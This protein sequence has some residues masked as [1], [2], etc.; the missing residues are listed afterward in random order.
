MQRRIPGLALPEVSPAH[1]GSGCLANHN[2]W[3]V[4]MDSGAAVA[5]DKDVSTVP[6]GPPVLNRILITNDDGI[7]APGL[8]VMEAIASELAREIW[9]VAPEHDQ[10]GISHAVSLHNPLRITHRPP[11]AA[12]GLTG[13][14][15]I[16]PCSASAI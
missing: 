11:P 4:P 16:A 13:R 15:A 5:I 8:S 10:S 7:D 2:E 3:A 9:V 14:R 6:E 1:A 12:T